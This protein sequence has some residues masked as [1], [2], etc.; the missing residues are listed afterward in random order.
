ME[1][2]FNGSKSSIPTSSSAGNP[3]AHQLS[4]R[5]LHMIN[6]LDPETG[7]PPEAVRQLIKGYESIGAEIEVVCLDPPH[8]AYIRD[9]HCPVHALD[10]SFGGRYSY[11][12]RLWRWL[13]ANIER[14][15]GIVMNGIW[16][17]PG[18]ALRLSAKRAGKSYGVFTHGALDPWFNR[19]YPFKH[20]KKLLYWP[21][22]YSVL[23]DAVAVFFTTSTERDLAKASFTP[24]DWN[25]VVVPYGIMEPVKS[26]QAEAECLEL[27]YKSLPRLRRRRYLLFLG[28]IHEKKGCDLLIE[29][30][31][32]L[33]G[34]APD[35]DLVMAG[36]GQTGMQAKLK[37]RA[38][39]L[40]VADRVH[41][42]GLITGDVKWGALKGCDAFILPSH[43]E[44]FGISVVEALCAGRSVL[45]SNQVNIWPD[46]R[47]DSAGL[48]DDDTLEGTSRMLR[49]WFTMHSEER[50][51]MADRARACF[52]AR[53]SMRRA[54]QAINNVF[55]S[56][57]AKDANVDESY[58]GSATGGRG[59]DQASVVDPAV[60]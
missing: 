49:R 23:R 52:V 36:P 55:S 9:V 31:A 19:K 8:A 15:D 29:A 54:A 4:M 34:L 37:R 33:T 13:K 18:V 10:Q 20:L 42:P 28:R 17:F 12:P 43:Q 5:I 30:F 50:N 1:S 38:E 11:S 14:F 59:I 21:I 35:M 32:G 25:S 56:I 7:G 45:I 27:F 39:Q 47:E 3:S 16:S 53:Y 40:G 46:I 22:Q 6:T 58:A 44:N 51:R 26:S 2:S 60:Q 41:W 57:A 48:V 24:S